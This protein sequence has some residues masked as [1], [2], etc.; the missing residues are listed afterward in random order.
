M[1]LAELA[2]AKGQSEQATR[3][4]REAVARLDRR[5]PE[6]RLDDDQAHALADRLQR[7]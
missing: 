1:A 6:G 4:A 7:P 5:L 3:L 2:A